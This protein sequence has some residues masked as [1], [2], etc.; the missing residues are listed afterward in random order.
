MADQRLTAEQSALVAGWRKMALGVAMKFWERSDQQL[1]A[2]EMIS[3]AYQ[4]LIQAALRFDPN[5]PGNDERYEVNPGFG[6]FAKQRVV[7][8]ILDWQRAQDHVP[9]R[10]RQTY[11][12]LQEYGHGTG[13][14]VDELVDL[15]G[16]PVDKIKA[17]VFAVE[18]GAVSLDEAWE[19]RETESDHR[20]ESSVMVST[21]NNAVADA[22]ASFPAQQRTIVYMRCYLAYDFNTIAAELGLTV[23]SVR[24]LYAESLT[25]LHS[26]FRNVAHT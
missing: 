20:V 5:R 8:A 15:V 2:D 18:S 9:R 21:V 11:K 6:Q 4:G 22:I 25:V 7:G 1:P 26:V 24:V 14:S 13:R 3:V 19:N 10:Q 23:T 16:L 12:K 17:I